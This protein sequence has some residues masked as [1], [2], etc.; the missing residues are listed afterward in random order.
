MIR[1]TPQ[2]IADFFGCYVF[3]GRARDNFYMTKGKPEWNG[4]DFCLHSDGM[5]SLIDKAVVDIPTGHDWTHLYEP[6]M[7]SAET[8]HTTDTTHLGEVYAHKEYRIVT[9]HKEIDSEAFSKG[10][11]A[12]IERG[13]RP[14]GGISFDKHGCPYQAMV[15]GI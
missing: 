14:A 6:Q 10:V 15:R 7:V 12:W 3:Q 8:A 9:A 5:L 11:M 1:R 2:E 4:A 13:W